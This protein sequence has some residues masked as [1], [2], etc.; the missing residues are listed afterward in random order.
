[1]KRWPMAAV[2]VLVLLL[3]AGYGSRP[4]PFGGSG[5]DF[6][7]TSVNAAASI[8]NG[9]HPAFTDQRTT[10]A[11]GTKIGMTTYRGKKSG[12]TGKVW[13]WAPPQYYDPRYAKS[14]FPVLIALPGSYGYPYNYWTRGDLGLQEDVARWA[15]QGSSLPFIVVMP[16]MNPGRSYH[17]CSDIPGQQKMGTW[18]TSD[19]PDLVRE[20]FRTFGSR[21]GWA[22]MGSSS[23][24]FCALKSVLQHPEAFKAAIV[25]GPDIVPDSSLWRGHP[26]EQQANNPQVLARRLIDR[27]GP[28]VCLAFQVGTAESRGEMAKVRQF[29]ADYGHG[30]VRTRLQTIVGGRHNGVSYLRGMEE[31]SVRWISDR[32]GAPTA[33]P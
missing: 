33:A 3:F 2:A 11:G 27:G 19:V 10:L 32:L 7:H 12:F 21:D 4:V 25:S 22:F 14:A 16:V 5:P 18:M 29:I 8:S 13:V 6:P 24:G 31:G 9:K 28:E 15:A 1:M 30:P 26:E 20:N 17:D 23:G